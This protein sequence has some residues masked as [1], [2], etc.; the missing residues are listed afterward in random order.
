MEALLERD[1]ELETLQTTL[2]SV[3]DGEGRVV[4][5]CGEAGI[6]KTTLVRRFLGLVN[7]QGLRLIGQ[8]ENLFTPEPLGPLQDMAA[9]LS[10]RVEELLR[11]RGSRLEIFAATLRA[12]QDASAPTVLVFEDVHWAD[13]ATLDLIR[14]LGRRLSEASI[15]L[16]L[17]Y[18]DD[19]VDRRHPLWSAL[20]NLPARSVVR[21][22]L[23]PLSEATVA[24]LAQERGHRRDVYRLSRGNPFFVTEL[25]AAPAGE[26][27][28]TIREAV[29]ARA[30]RLPD[31]A[32]D[33]LDFCAILPAG[34]PLSLVEAAFGPSPAELERCLRTGL[35]VLN[36]GVVRFRHELVRQ[37]V[38]GA[39]PEL[40]A[41]MLHARM[42][43]LNGIEGS[44]PL[45]LAQLLH[46]AECAGKVEMIV[47]VAPKAAEEAIAVGAHRAA[48][49]HLALALRHE[50]SFELA[51]YT[52]LLERHAYECYLIADMETAIAE[53]LRALER[54]RG[55]RNVRKVS[56][57][58]R[59]LSR[60]F[61]FSGRFKEAMAKAEEAIAVLDLAQSTPEL[62]WALSN[63]AQLNFLDTRPT[64]AVSHARNAIEMADKLGLTEL[65]VHALN[66][67]GAAQL[68]LHNAEGWNSLEESL[69][70]A[71]A[72]NMHEHACRAYTNLSFMAAETREYARAKA[73]LAEGMA[74]SRDY[75]LD[76]WTDDM[77]GVLSR[78]RL[79]TGRWKE[80]VDHAQQL[81]DTPGV[82][83]SRII[84]LTVLGLVRLRRGDPG[85]A[86]VLAEASAIAESTGAIMR[87]G[88]VRAALAE[89]AWIE[90]DTDRLREMASSGLALARERGDS[91][92]SATFAVW[93]RLAG[94]TVEI[95][96]APH[97]MSLLRA[98]KVEEAAQ[99]WL[100]LGCAYDA[101]LSLLTGDGA[102][103]IEALE[104]LDELGATQS[105][106]RVRRNLREAGVR[107]IPRGAN[108]RTRDNPFGL[109][110]RESEV[111]GMIA[112]HLSNREIAAQLFVSVRTVDHHVSSILA[113]L[114][115]PNREGAVRIVLT[116][117]LDA[118]IGQVPSEK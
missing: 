22:P 84:P 71:I 56:E 59:L 32:R 18:R 77:L 29:L 63:L 118:R 13:E 40:A 17:T 75:D 78:L 28:P 87:V 43:D 1:D 80:A 23:A 106:A 111:L 37:A 93:L 31:A 10:D 85:A 45:P 25:M 103:Q 86:E 54:R 39:L 65:H 61:W 53:R 26:M 82:P 92:Q 62:G 99:A 115:V 21:L 7:D 27:P 16:V 94:E 46:H 69:Q 42:L 38:E 33:V 95:A 58:L 50:A 104:L 60:L 35:V 12:L 11:A 34:A 30:S 110:A 5:V 6:G 52:D 41:A 9:K 116:H 101:A 100:D 15:L 79:D 105:A 114:N 47:A 8:C 19:E 64:T 109:T 98:G 83:I 48:A 70:L 72:H 57:N 113:K 96:P 91:I 90:G 51:T 24:A 88:P 112:E 44:A 3:R 107:S 55:E 49:A 4:V 76:Y 97:P 2:A 67:L 108:R 68:Q 81:L 74:F 73:Y 102:N 117:G 89:Q 36:D 14:F 20:G 66:N